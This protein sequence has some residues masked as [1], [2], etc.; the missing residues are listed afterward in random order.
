[1]DADRMLT[2]QALR[3]RLEDER[4]EVDAHATA[5]AIVERLLAGLGA[6]AV[7]DRSEQRGY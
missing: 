6:R 2:L 1:M 7:S 3:E 4:Y 5:A